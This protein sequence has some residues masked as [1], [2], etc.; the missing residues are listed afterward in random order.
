MYF[1][2][3]RRRKNRNGRRDRYAAG[4]ERWGFSR[5]TSRAGKCFLNPIPIYSEITYPHLQFYLPDFQCIA[6]IDEKNNLQTLVR[7]QEVPIFASQF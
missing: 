3:R 1:G 2:I 6:I 7:F 4:S 5:A